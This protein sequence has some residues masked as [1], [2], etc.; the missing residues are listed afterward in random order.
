MATRKEYEMLFKLGAQLGQDFN[1]SFS[2]AQKILSQTQK[3]IA[4][5]Q[6]VQSDITAYSKQNQSIADTQNKLEMYEK[7]LKA[8]KAELEA[9]GGSS[10][11]LASKEA[12]LE[13]KVKSTAASLQQKKDKLNELGQALEDAGVDT[14]KL[15]DESKKLKDKVNELKDA[16]NVAGEEAKVM[17][18]KSESAFSQ[19]GEALIAAG[20]A[21]GLKEIVDYYAECADGAA[22]YADEIGTM[23]V[24]YG[25]A[26][27]DLQAYTYAAELLDV[28]V[29][30]ITSSLAR[31]TRAMYNAADGSAQYVEAYD[32]IGISVTDANGNLRDAQTVYWEA[33]DAL[34]AMTNETERD[35]IAMTLLGRNAMELNTLIKAGSGVMNEYTAMAEEAGYI[36]SEE[37]LE[38][39]CALD[40]QEQIQQKNLQGLK[41]TIGAAVAPELIKLKQIQNEMLVSVTEF[42]AENPGIVKGVVLI[43]GALSTLLSVYTAYKGAKVAIIALRKLN[44]LLIKEETAAK[45]AST[46][47]TQG[48]TAAQHGFNAAMNANPVGVFAVSLT[49]LIGLFSVLKNETKSASYELLTLSRDYAKRLKTYKKNQGN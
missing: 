25:I 18:D 27:K 48:A 23:S 16:E 17:G 34:S 38:T 22:A 9:S 15:A 24:Q 39:L 26:A 6:K 20:V 47:A 33:I 8:V 37:V 10:A 29:N 44:K 19:M 42:A 45:V 7:Q 41:N 14:S 49:S 12:D 36:M 3:E 5:L 46:T 32:K 35:G 43:A 11:A 1:G 40:D 21:K 28:D 31:N 2:Q 13:Y 4:A 30:T